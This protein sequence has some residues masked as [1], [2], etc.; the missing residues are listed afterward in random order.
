MLGLYGCALVINQLH[1]KIN[2]PE[3]KTYWVMSSNSFSFI[4]N[5]RFFFRLAVN[6]LKLLEKKNTELALKARKE[7]A[8]YI[9]AGKAERG[10]C[11]IFFKCCADFIN[12]SSFLQLK[13]VLNKSL[14]KII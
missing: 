7:I 10:L 5:V 1:T 12:I 13:S 4:F 3:L 2:E 8:D 9:A 11:Y 14:G 6:R